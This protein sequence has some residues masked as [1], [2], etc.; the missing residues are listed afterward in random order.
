MILNL[1][2]PRLYVCQYVKDGE[3]CSFR[4]VPGDN[5]IPNSEAKALLAHPGIKRKIDKGILVVKE[6]VTED[7][8]KVASAH[9]QKKKE[10]ELKK[11]AEEVEKTKSNVNT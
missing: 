1:T 6:R 5:K 11:S 10:A 9:T 7:L 2:L 4:F 3:V 8:A